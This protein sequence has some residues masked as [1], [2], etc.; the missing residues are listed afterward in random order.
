MTIFQTVR[1]CDF[2][3]IPKITLNILFRNNDHFNSFKQIFFLLFYFL[4]THCL[5]NILIFQFHNRY[6]YSKTKTKR[7]IHRLRKRVLSIGVRT[8]VRRK[9]YNIHAGT[10][11]CIN[12]QCTFYVS[13]LFF[14]VTP[15]NNRFCQKFVWN[16]NLH[17]SIIFFEVLPTL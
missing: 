17:F 15:K 10:T 8:Y 13:R 1:W 7:V 11:S 6:F 9:Q 3:I 12:I 16:K 5:T 2:L 14:L 4:K